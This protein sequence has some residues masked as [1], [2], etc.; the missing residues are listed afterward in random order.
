MCYLKMKLNKIIIW[1]F[2]LHSHTHSYIHN[3]FFRAFRSLGYEVYWYNEKGKNNYPQFGINKDFENCLYIVVGVKCKYLPIN[4]TSYYIWHTGTCP[5]YK[6][7]EGDEYLCPKISSTNQRIPKK[8]IIKLHTLWKPC[9]NVNCNDAKNGCN[10]WSHNA[11]DNKKKFHNSDYYYYNLENNIIYMPWAT[12]LL[13]NEIDMNI[14]KLKKMETKNVSNFIGMMTPHWRLYAQEC[15]KYNIIFQHNGG[16]FN[17]YSNKNKSIKENMELIQ[18]SILAPALQ[19]KHQKIHEYIPCRIFK[20]IS[21]GKMGITNNAAVNTLFNNT[22]IY[23]NNMREL[24]QKGMHF[25]KNNYEYMKRLMIEVRDHHTYI[26]R[27]KFILNF[28]NEFKD[29]QVNKP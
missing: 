14:N 22:L 26:N 29:I 13:P 18:E 1:G 25:E 11:W 7:F 12:D 2:E 27:V 23:S 4:E 9:K 6:E 24:I 3:A 15:S 28:L 17:K 8:N 21:Y 19:D 5:I 10:E 16:T 20:N